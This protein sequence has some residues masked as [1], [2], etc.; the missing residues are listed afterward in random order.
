MS[1]RNEQRA[2]FIQKTIHENDMVMASWDDEDAEDGQGRML[3]KGAKKL[4]A[5]RKEGGPEPAGIAVIGCLSREEA[6]LIRS[7]WGDEAPP[8]K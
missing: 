2:K 1:I 6:E 3:I 5:I 4:Q 7:I 8:L